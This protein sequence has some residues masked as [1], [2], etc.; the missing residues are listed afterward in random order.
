MHNYIHALLH[1]HTYARTPYAHIVTV[2]YIYRPIYT[3]YIRRHIKTPD[4]RFPVYA[5]ITV[6][7]MT[8]V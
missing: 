1:A 2:T 8:S 5:H 6:N 7:L 4:A 3:M